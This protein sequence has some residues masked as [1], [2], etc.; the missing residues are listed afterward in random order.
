MSSGVITSSLYGRASA[1]ARRAPL[2]LLPL[3]PL[4]LGAGLA[5][6]TMSVVVTTGTIT[7]L[8]GC[9]LAVLDR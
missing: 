3:A 5:C 8:G 6:V 9:V 1:G 7:A 2:P 4:V